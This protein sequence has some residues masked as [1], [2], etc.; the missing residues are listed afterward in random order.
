MFSVRNIL[1]SYFLNVSTGC[2]CP[3]CKRK[4][5]IEMA[6]KRNA[7]NKKP[8]TVPI[9]HEDEPE[10]MADV[11][12]HQPPTEDDENQR[13]LFQL[14]QEE[15]DKNARLK[16]LE[17]EVRKNAREAGIKTYETDSDSDSE[18]AQR[19]ARM[20]TARQVL[21]LPA[22]AKKQAAIAEAAHKKMLWITSKI[23]PSPTDRQSF[24]TAF[25]NDFVRKAS[26]LS[27]V[28]REP[29]ER[30][31][32]WTRAIGRIHVA[33]TALGKRHREHGDEKP[34]KKKSSSKP[35]SEPA[36]NAAGAAGGAAVAGPVPDVAPAATAV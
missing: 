3:D 36:A 22:E 5:E 19:E 33:V 15:L 23:S 4:R 1:A 9:V 17:E 27:P 13:R 29:L 10:P 6:S 7:A 24:E 2:P 28:Y 18:E 35:K 12:S 32:G 25:E 8:K 14:K 30:Q 21:G 34:A 26:K 20:Q 16:A 31:L 11:T